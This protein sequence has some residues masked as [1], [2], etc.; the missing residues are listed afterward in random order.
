MHLSS[1]SVDHVFIN[2][3]DTSVKQLDS[4]CCSSAEFL[5]MLLPYLPVSSCKQLFGLYEQV[6]ELTI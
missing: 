5:D 1:V 3:L 4:C 6:L 2:K